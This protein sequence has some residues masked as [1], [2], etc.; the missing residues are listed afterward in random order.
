[1][2]EVVLR[3]NLDANAI[4]SILSQMSF[5]EKI[6]I[7]SEL[8]KELRSTLANLITSI[9]KENQSSPMSLEEIT[10]EIEE[11]RAKR[12]ETKA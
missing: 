8:E 2:S 12:Y 4:L 3:T 1:M 10:R 11:I 5:E 6:C 7:Y 9:R